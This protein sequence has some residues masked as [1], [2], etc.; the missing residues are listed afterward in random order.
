MKEN[1]KIQAA[2]N[3][4]QCGKPSHD[5]WGTFPHCGKSSHDPWETLPHCAHHTK[6]SFDIIHY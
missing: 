3:L 6:I 2:G 4:P 1:E 5:P